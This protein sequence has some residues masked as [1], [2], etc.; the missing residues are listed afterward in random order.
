MRYTTFNTTQHDQLKEPMFLG[1]PVNVLRFDEQRFPIFEKLTDKQLSFF[2]RPEEIDVSK[3]RLDFQSLPE[4]ER[5]IFL[6]NL[7]FQTLADA[8]AGRSIAMAT[9]PA[10]S[11]PELEAMYELFSAVESAIHSKSYSHIIRNVFDNPTEVFNGIIEIDEIVERS[12]QI[13]RYYDDLIEYTSWFNLLGEGNHS[14]NGESK[15]IALPEL[16][17][18][19][20]LAILSLNIMEGVRFYV[21]FA[22]SFAFA[23]RSL[24]EG[25]AKIIK[26]IAR[27]EAL[28]TSAGQHVI[29]NWRTGKDDPE[30][31]EILRDNEQLAYQMFDEV[32]RD[33][34]A[35]ADYLFRD[36]SMIGLNAEILKQYV[37]YIANQR[38]QQIGLTPQYEV[39]NNPLPWMNT[40]LVSDN[41]Q[42]APQ[43]TEITSYLVGAIDSDVDGEDFGDFAL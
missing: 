34:K 26:L 23:E 28:H 5:H 33:E 4:H 35:W 8:A 38:M 18:K 37:E 11:L 20:F 27:D 2:W 15:E 32:V 36:G 1:E 12:T 14:I 40:W 22:C 29:N 16:K 25:N 3:D 43:E 9:L 19:L 10:V 17:K 30:M 13:C 41:V 24:M 39:S 42:V 31:A 7:R 6:S 21:S